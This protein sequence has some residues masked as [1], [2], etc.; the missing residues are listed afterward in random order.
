MSPHMGIEFDVGIGTVLK[1]P[2]ASLALFSLN[3]EHQSQ[4]LFIL[5]RV[6]GLCCAN[7]KKK[8]SS[9]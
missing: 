6:F 2:I 9:H 8:K 7:A 5:N 3:N 4:N 1:Y